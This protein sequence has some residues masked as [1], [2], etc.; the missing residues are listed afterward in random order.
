MLMRTDHRGD[1][2]TTADPDLGHRFVTALAA[3]DR[4]TLVS[5]LDDEVDFQA[6]TPRRSW[7][8]LTGAAVIDDVILGKWFSPGDII[9]LVEFTETGLVG[10]RHSLGYRVQVTNSDGRWLVEQRAYL[11]ISDGR[12]SWLR[13]LCSGY[14][15]I[16]SR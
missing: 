8:E 9:D 12:I 16:E 14:Q 6:M 10:N 13:M 2:S 3:K 1:V 7:Q 11:D 15:P 4:Q 5:L